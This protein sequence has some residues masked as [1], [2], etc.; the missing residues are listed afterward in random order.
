MARDADGDRR[1]HY[2]FL[3]LIIYL[4]RPFL[5][6]MIT[7]FARPPTARDRFLTEDRSPLRRPRAY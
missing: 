5:A 7:L 3:I 1:L 4:F 2:P 6:R